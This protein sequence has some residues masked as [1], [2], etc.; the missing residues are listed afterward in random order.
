MKR[1]GQ[2]AIVLGVALLCLATNPS[3]ARHQEKIKE[4]FRAENR[5]L[6]KIGL[7]EVYARSFEYR[8]YL[9][10]SLTR[11]EGEIKSFGVLGMVFTF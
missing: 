7:G 4:A 1:L 9:L 10:C 3:Q 5:V 2:V 8:N 6:G 11:A